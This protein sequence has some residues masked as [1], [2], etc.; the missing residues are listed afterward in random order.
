MHSS[1]TSRQADWE[2]KTWGRAGKAKEVEGA[3]EVVVV[4]AAVAVNGRSRRSKGRR[5][6]RGGFRRGGCILG[7]WK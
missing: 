4:V 7:G 2:A 3:A 1:Y 5:G 6:K